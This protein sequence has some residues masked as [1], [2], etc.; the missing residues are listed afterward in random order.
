VRHQRYQKFDIRPKKVEYDDIRFDS[1]L[2]LLF[3]KRIIKYPSLHVVY[4][5]LLR[6]AGWKWK[7][8]FGLY[9]ANETGRSLLQ[10][11]NNRHGVFLFVEVKGILDKNFLKKY[12]SIIREEINNDIIILS[13]DYKA[14]IFPD[15][16]QSPLGYLVKPVYPMKVFFDILDNSNGNISRH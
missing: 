15:T 12:N 13:T 1:K 6:G 5:P 3:Y 11:F 16:T 10:R 14:A 9:P 7:V 2:E 8:D 4:K